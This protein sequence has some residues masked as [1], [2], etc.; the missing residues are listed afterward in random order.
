VACVNWIEKGKHEVHR[1]EL[2]LIMLLQVQCEDTG[3]VSK[4]SETR[5]IG[6]ISKHSETRD[7]GTISKHSETRDI[8]TITNTRKHVILVP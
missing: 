8:G 4:H 6:T 7:I 1:A 5:D 2:K 3:T